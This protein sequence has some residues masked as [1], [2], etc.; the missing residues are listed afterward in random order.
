MRV[1]A[2]NANPPSKPPHVPVS[3]GAYDQN[4]PSERA[5]PS[6]IGFD[7][8]RERR[9]R[10]SGREAAARGMPIGLSGGGL[11]AGLESGLCLGYP[12]SLQHS[13]L[14]WETLP[15]DLQFMVE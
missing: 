5:P 6:M 3:H 13:H 12:R 10:I 8:G 14:G 1:F 15:G 9:R 4:P 11:G 2:S 7:E